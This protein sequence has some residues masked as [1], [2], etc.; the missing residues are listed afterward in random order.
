MQDVKALIQKDVDN[1][2]NI[3][4]VET[5]LLTGFQWNKKKLQTAYLIALGKYT[6]TDISIAV[7]IDRK[8]IY[9]WRK[10]KEFS[11]KITEFIMSYGLADKTNRIQGQ[12]KI[13]E[14]I[15]NILVEKLDDNFETTNNLKITPLLGKYY[16]GLKLIAKEKG[17]FN[18]RPATDKKI[19]LVE[20]LKN[21]PDQDRKK[22]VDLFRQIAISSIERRNAGQI[23]AIAG[24][25]VTAGQPATGE[26]IDVK[27]DDSLDGFNIE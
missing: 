15:E 18:I 12:K 3:P 8:T 1:I 7:D 25:P 9:G 5:E 13:L 6:I 21:I 26:I 11:D 22:L 10:Y 14:K 27:P 4:P 24:R 2:D 17:D 20:Y 23:P 19:D 16:D